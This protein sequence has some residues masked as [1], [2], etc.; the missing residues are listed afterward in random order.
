M[1][2]KSQ[3]I[4]SCSGHRP[5]RLMG[6]Y[7]IP[8][9]IYNYIYKESKALLT[10]IQPNKV[11]TG[12]ALGYDQIIAAICIKL[13]IP[14]VAVCPFKG[15]ESRWNNDSQRL[16]NYLLSKACEVIIV[17]EGS[18]SVEKMHLRDQYLVDHSK[19]L[20]A[21][22]DG[23]PNGGTHHTVQYAQSK[24]KDIILIDPNKYNDKAN[25]TQ[26]T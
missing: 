12:M 14:F 2:E 3:S 25:Q 7:D 9:P 22:Y 8:N 10:K 26:N 6:T 13:N 15:Q 20:M 16:Y 19:T 1:E 4:I 23:V 5:M 11:L 24:N 21:C 17:S 18:F